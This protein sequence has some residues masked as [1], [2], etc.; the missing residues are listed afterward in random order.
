V[1]L[2]IPAPN[3]RG[4]DEDDEDLYHASMQDMLSAYSFAAPSLNLIQMPFT[5][6]KDLLYYCFGLSYIG[7][8]PLTKA[9]IYTF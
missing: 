9:E 6:L 7:I 8:P 5:T 2:N 3:L 1:I 4:A